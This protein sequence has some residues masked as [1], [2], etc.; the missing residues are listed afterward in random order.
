MEENMSTIVAISTA[1]GIGGIG[2]IR[3]SGENSFSILEKIFRQKKPQKIED[4][5]GYTIKYGKIID[6]KNKQIIDEV[7]VSYF[8]KPNSYTTEDMC[9]INSHGGVIV[10]QKILEICLENGAQMAEAGEFTK[11]AF[12]NGRIDLSQAESIIDIINSKTEKEAKASI[13]QLNGFLSNKI[14]D[15]KKDIL[16][17][18]VDIEASID[19]PEYDIEEVSY[20]KIEDTLYKVKGKLEELERTFYNGKIIKEGI[21]VAI[22]GKPNAGKSSLLNAILREERA[23]VTEYEGTTRDTIE[24]FMNIDGI[25]LKLI[26]TAGIRNAKD[27]VEKIGIE[28]A[29]EI[30]KEADL[31][32][33]IF[34][35]TKELD[36]EDKKIIEEFEKKKAIIVLNKID[37]IS[38]ADKIEKELE[39]LNKPI[40]KISALK[41][42][43]IEKLNQTI[44][45]LFKINDI[46]VDNETIVTNTRHKEM[47]RKAKE[48]NNEALQTLKAKMPLD[49]ITVYIKEILE[50]LGNITGENVSENIIN[51]I[52]AKFC[53]GK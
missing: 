2:I 22:I 48:Y 44:S 17:V 46:Q 7:L 26:D 28:K 3:M 16:D 38:Q 24:E 49:V 13:H 12:L 15:I 8:K 10:M 35:A 50:A 36:N 21:K 9:E 47:I 37:L 27:E 30:A 1:P 32:I 6:P 5:K 52:F 43:G 41:R 18:M 33:A 31:I 34:D 19:Y 40:V 51:E 14:N 53:L 25:P 39:Y 11:R 4:I 42:E 20:Q 29:K 45:E 23:I